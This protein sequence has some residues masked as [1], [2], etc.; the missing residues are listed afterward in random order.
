MAS[1]GIPPLQ[2]QA[3]DKGC[4][5]LKG[6]GIK[7]IGRGLSLGADEE[8]LIISRGNHVIREV[9]ISEIS[10]VIL[11]SK[12]VS[13]SSN[14]IDLMLRYGIE[15]LIMRK[16]RFVGKLSP[17]KKEVPVDIKLAQYKAMNNLLGLKLAK[18]FIAGKLQN[19]S[20]L[21]TYLA[22]SGHNRKEV[23]YG[24]ETI[25]SMIS[26]VKELNGPSE[27]VRGKILGIEREADKIYWSSIASVLPNWVGFNGRRCKEP[28]DP[29]NLSLNFLYGTLLSEVQLV[30]ESTGFEP[31]LGFLHVPDSRRAALAMDF[32]MEFRQPV[33]DRA[34]LSLVEEMR[35]F[36]KD[37]RLRPRA[38]KKLIDA[39]EG[40]MNM[41]VTFKGRYLP[42]RWHMDLQARR[43]ASVV[44]GRSKAYDPFRVNP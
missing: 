36:I 31:F 20:D 10:R 27:T 22:K 39:Y 29:I 34:V 5:T 30:L 9:S 4:T 1:A 23:L 25:R 37:S 35:G 21:L 44:M 15:F 8:R 26:A 38:K 16:G 33:V 42:I 2:A 6:K 18:T 7:V 12:G 32:M 3:L 11:E 19:Q 17:M 24:A 14:A 40:I 41:E 43:L 13:I 28:E